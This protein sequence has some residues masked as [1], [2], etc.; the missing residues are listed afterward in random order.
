M[1]V[2]GLPF[3]GDSVGGIKWSVVKVRIGCTRNPC[4]ELILGI[5]VRRS[6]NA[7]RKPVLW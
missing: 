6:S 2:G 5:D 3:A 7:R 4:A 1:D